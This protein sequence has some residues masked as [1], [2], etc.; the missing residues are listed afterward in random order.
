[1][2]W[3]SAVSSTINHENSTY[4]FTPIGILALG[5]RK[6][7]FLMRRW[8]YHS[9]FFLGR[10][11]IMCRVSFIRDKRP[12]VRPQRVSLKTRCTNTCQTVQHGMNIFFYFF[13]K[14]ASWII[15]YIAGV[16]WTISISILPSSVDVF[17]KP[18]RH[19]TLK[20]VARRKRSDE[21]GTDTTWV[22]QIQNI[23]YRQVPDTRHWT[24]LTT[25]LYSFQL[26]CSHALS[27]CVLS[28]GDHL[29]GYR[30][31]FLHEGHINI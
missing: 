17:T 13:W 10:H 26:T 29:K 1:M 23:M 16:M 7:I 30:S 25:R 3:S 11:A 12:F 5:S 15:I 31:P 18:V 2:S 27:S 21:V 19:S 28:L 9:G 20:F 8:E 24:C 22:L 14:K 6:I 4:H